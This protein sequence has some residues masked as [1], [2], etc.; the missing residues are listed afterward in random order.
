MT[1]DKKLCAPKFGGFVKKRLPVVIA[2]SLLAPALVWAD[3][4]LEEVVVTATKRETNLQDV[5]IAVQALT[6]EKLEQQNINNFS[7]YINFMPAVSFQS[8]RPGVSQVYMRGISSGGDGNHSGS[9]PSVA[10]YLD[11]QPVTTI[12]QVLDVHVYDVARIETLSGPQGTLFGSSAQAGTLRIITNQPTTESFEAAMDVGVNSTKNGG[13]GNSVEGFVNL[14]INERA[15]LRVVGWRQED[16]GYIDS[17][18]GSRTYAA[19]GITVTNDQYVEKDFNDSVTEGMR[20]QLKVD[21]NDNWTANLGVNTQ[22][23]ETN[24]VFDHDPEDVGDL[25]VV[26][27]GPDKYEESWTQSSLTLTGSVGGLEV[28]YAGAHLDRDSDWASDYSAYAEYLENLYADYGY[29]CLYYNSMGGCAD[30]TQYIDDNSKYRRT[31]HELRVQSDQENR[32]RWIAGA[33]YQ[34]QVHDF[35]MR[36]QVP[37]LST[38]DSVIENGHVVWQTA[39]VRKDT[40]RALFGEVSYD[41]T[42]KLTGMVGIRHFDLENSLV[43]FA[44]TLGRCTD[45]PCVD[46]PNVDAVTDDKGETYK[47]NLSYALNDDVMLYTTY[48]EGYRPGGVNRAQVGVV[49]PAYSPDWVYNYEFGWKATLLDN[50]MRFNGSIYRVDWEN[51]QYAY[52]DYQVSPLTLITNVGQSRTNGME[53]DLTYAASEQ[54]L[55][56]LSG[57]FNAAELQDDYYQTDDDRLEGIVSAPTGTAMPFVPETQLSATARYEME[58]GSM[59]AYVQMAWSHTD[60]SWNSL[61]VSLRQKQAAYDLVNMSAGLSGEQ[62][63]ADMF[64]SNLTDERAEIYRNEND[65][66]ARITTNRPRSIGV[67]LGYRF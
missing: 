61:D 11:E 15:A 31:S 24:G 60:D 39:Q 6:N 63:S 32:L 67:R 22:Q 53:F 41:L 43:G 23:Q 9:Q 64:V 45:F 51:F 38:D 55:L 52:L 56:S 18:A 12:N 50:R 1:I 28:T 37:E 5:P 66:D 14:P 30:P 57:S 35:D 3:A 62:W 36:W 34:E 10:V 21:L 48:S 54:L 29:D 8:T 58:L 20:A 44:G 2:S 26:R 65:Y 33:F 46:Y 40:D 7:D 59:P 19:S 17:V 16:A 13:V 49:S 42:E 4:S 27:F 25:E 47:V